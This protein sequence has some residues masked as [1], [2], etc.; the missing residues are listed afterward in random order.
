MAVLALLLAAFAGGLA[1]VA[2]DRLVLLPHMSRGSGFW[3][4]RGPGRPSRD[5]D[6][7]QRFARELGLTAEQQQ[8][9]DS[10]MDRQGREMRAVRRRVQPQVDSIVSRTRREL[11]VVLTPEQRAKAEAIR[12]RHPRPPKPPPP[13]DFP[14]GPAPDGP[15]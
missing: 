10:I 14:P 11:D 5:R 3:H 15:R 12:K 13:D 4:D 8:R 1:G 9:I 6:F 2:I 7:R